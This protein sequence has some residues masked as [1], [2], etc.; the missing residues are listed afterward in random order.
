LTTRNMSI[1]TPSKIRSFSSPNDRITYSS[2]DSYD[3][4]DI[5]DP[6]IISCQLPFEK[7]TDVCLAVDV[8]QNYHP[9]LIGTKGKK[10]RELMEMAKCTINFPNLNR[11]PKGPKINNVLVGGDV[12]GVEEV[13][14]EIRCRTPI[15]LVISG[16]KRRP[17][18]I[19]LAIDLATEKHFYS[20]MSSLNYQ[21]HRDSIYLK[22]DW[23]KDVLLGNF[24]YDV[25]TEGREMFSISLPCLSLINVHNKDRNLHLLQYIKN[26]TGCMIYY[27]E[28]EFVAN[29][30]PSLIVEGHD[31]FCV[32]LAARIL[33]GLTMFQMSF[34]M[35]RNFHVEDT[36]LKRFRCV[37]FVDVSIEDKVN[38]LDRC[39]VVLRTFEFCA[40]KAYAIHG[41]I[42]GQD[43]MVRKSGYEFMEDIIN[44]LSPDV[45]GSSHLYFTQQPF[46]PEMVYKMSPTPDQ[47]FKRFYGTPSDVARPLIDLPDIQRCSI[48]ED[49]ERA[50]KLRSLHSRA[51]MTSPC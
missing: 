9:F 31:P 41:A 44:L 49:D 6:A 15:R 12:S 20:S 36:E 46:D 14:K 26:R 34:E 29:A 7:S 48:V 37:H 47:F 42:L 23:S 25:F 19:R 21:I 33:F 5:Y 22:S 13:R 4:F 45:L 17:E 38:S 39:T 27:P 43:T 16:F 2:V 1:Y 30:P 10:C 35:P 32:F 8:A 18:E 51:S 24:C 50:F 3:A 11:I 40:N 28:M